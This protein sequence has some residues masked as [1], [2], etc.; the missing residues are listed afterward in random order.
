[1]AETNPNGRPTIYTEKLA[2]T[3]CSRLAKGESLRTIC[4]DDEMPNAS[5]VHAWVNEKESFSKQYDTA[6]A[7]QAKA[8]FD[9]ILEIADDGTS[10]FVTKKNANGQE[11]E[12][13]DSE[14][15]SRSRLR[16]DAR[17]WYLSKVLPKVY[18]DKMDLTTDG[19]ALPSPIL[20]A[21]IKKEE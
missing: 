7:E 16:V 20:S 14:H 18:G 21:I 15:I 1:M 17:K 10:D 2:E 19:E 3:I 12:A 13:V 4:R 11:Y 8:L 6:R 9:E 5:T